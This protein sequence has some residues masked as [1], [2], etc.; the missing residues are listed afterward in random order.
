[1]VLWLVVKRFPTTRKKRLAL[2]DGGLVK[3]GN[4]PRGEDRTPSFAM[5]RKNLSWPSSQKTK[6]CIVLKTM[7]FT[8]NLGQQRQVGIGAVISC[9]QLVISCSQLEEPSYEPLAS[10]IGWKHVLHQ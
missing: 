9:S 10:V 1:M 7:Y 2:S 3:P 8:R 4:S 5:G 6:L